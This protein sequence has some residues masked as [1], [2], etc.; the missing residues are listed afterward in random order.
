MG[1]QV[2]DQNQSKSEGIPSWI[3][4]LTG[5]VSGAAAVAGLFMA[6]PDLITVVVP[7]TTL[8]R[9]IERAQPN[10]AGQPAAQEAPIQQSTPAQA[11]PQVAVAAQSLQGDLSATLTSLA[12]TP[13]ALVANVR[14]TNNS[15]AEVLIAG[16]LVQLGVGDFSAS[17]PLGGACRWSNSG[18]AQ[19]SLGSLKLDSGQ[20]SAQRLAYPQNY[21]SVGPGQS[22]L[23]TLL[24]HKYACAPPVSGTQ[25]VTLSGT[26]VIAQDDQ[27]R[28]ASASFENVTPAQ[29]P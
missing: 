11:P 3:S 28:F 4:A 20:I 19:L 6:Q 9:V 8:E 21:T 27:V 26:F 5:L 16:R 2:T 22:V 23:V 12:N 14:L 7:V 1:G 25:P 24:F 17:D 10:P 13:D 15:A 18:R 29:A